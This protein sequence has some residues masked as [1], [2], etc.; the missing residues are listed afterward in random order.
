MHYCSNW[1]IYNSVYCWLPVA[2][3]ALD[4]LQSPVMA[5]YPLVL[6]LV[7]RSYGFTFSQCTSPVYI[8]VRQLSCVAGAAPLQC[9]SLRRVDHWSLGASICSQGTPAQLARALLPRAPFFSC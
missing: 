9:N 7:L 8:H 4:R 6:Y 5:P 1:C 3:Q 2:S